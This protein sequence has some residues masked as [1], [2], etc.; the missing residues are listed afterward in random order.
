VFLNMLMAV[1]DAGTAKEAAEYAAREVLATPGLEKFAGGDS[2]AIG[3]VLLVVL[4]VVL[5]LWLL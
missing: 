1:Q 5:I 2:I 4:I 3:G